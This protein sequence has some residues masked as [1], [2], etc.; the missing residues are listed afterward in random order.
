MYEKSHKRKISML[1]MTRSH[2]FAK[3]VESDFF[4]SGIVATK[5]D[6]E[7]NSENKQEYKACQILLRLN[8]WRW[9]ET[10]KYCKLF[11]AWTNLLDG[12]RLVFTYISLLLHYWLNK[13]IHLRAI[14]DKNY[15]QQFLV[16]VIFAARVSTYF[17]FLYNSVDY[18]IYWAIVDAAII[19]KN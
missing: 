3:N 13:S 5:N 8:Q 15:P 4:F 9:F 1:L 7:S 12:Y 16:W 18:K 6:A 19:Q 17:L 2:W 11:Y 14:P 10:D